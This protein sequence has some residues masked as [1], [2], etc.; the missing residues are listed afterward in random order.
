MPSKVNGTA[1]YGIDVQV[2]GMVYASLLHA[3]MDGVKAESVNAD[4]VKKIKG[5]TQVI[6][7]PFG[8]AVVADTVEATPRWAAMRSR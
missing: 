2:P 3:P 1:K 7:L 6:P 8:V 4:E 5:V